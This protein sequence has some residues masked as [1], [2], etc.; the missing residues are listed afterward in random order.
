MVDQP[1]NPSLAT[2][3]ICTIRLEQLCT[4]RAWWFRVF[5]E[6][7]ASGI[8][9]FAIA[10]RIPRDACTARSPMCRR[11]LR[12]RKNALK[13]RSRLFTWLDGHL[14]PLF[15]RVRDSLLT[16]AELEQARTLAR[17]AADRDFAGEDVRRP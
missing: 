13:E 6:A 14:N 15:N 3:G 4:R 12:F 17:R 1:P 11:C 2:C 9:L 7:L 10:Y 5:R 16:P 8:R